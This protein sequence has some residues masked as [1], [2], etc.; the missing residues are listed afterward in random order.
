MTLIVEDGTARAD[1]EALCSLT[2]ADAHHAGRGVTNWALLSDAEKEQALRRAT[3]YMEQVYGPLWL[4]YRVTDTQ[5]LDW[6][7]KDVPR[8]EVDGYWAGDIVPPAVVKAC[9]ELALR[10]AAGPLLPDESREVVEQ[11]VGPITTK[12]A[13]G[14]PQAPRYAA[15]DAMLA[16]LLVS[17]RGSSVMR[18]VRS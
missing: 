15:V 10:A 2:T 14:S 16:L 8:R 11:T 9:A 17:A 1:A 5:A 12:Y 18:L 13:Q 7:R 4:G 6:P 3:A